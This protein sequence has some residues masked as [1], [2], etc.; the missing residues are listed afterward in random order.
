MIPLLSRGIQ[1]N[2]IG[3]LVSNSEAIAWRG[4]MASKAIYQ[5]LSLT[6]W[7]NLDYLIIDMPPG[8]GDIHLSILENY[9]ING[10]VVIVTSPQKISEIDVTKAINLY[11][12]FDLPIL[13]IIENMSYFIDPES[14]KIINIFSGNSGENLASKHKVPLIFKLPLLPEIAKACDLGKSLA[15]IELG[16]DFISFL[17]N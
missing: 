15:D 12:K 4:P 8:T 17:V 5:L 10:G 2:S 11:Q 14:G 7:Q 3:F 16:K 13:G 9:Q 1:V 6:D